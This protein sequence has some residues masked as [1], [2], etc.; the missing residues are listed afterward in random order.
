VGDVRGAQSR[1]LLFGSS[2]RRR[3]SPGTRS[4]SS[5][6]WLTEVEHP[7]L[8]AKLQYPGRPYD[9]SETPW[10]SAAGRAPGE[11]NDEIYAG[12]LGL[13]EADL[14]ALKSAAVI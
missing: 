8:G 9:F 2:A 14:A 5:R 4:S 6:K 10:R 11:H 12:E 7:E 3:T 13:D 1:R